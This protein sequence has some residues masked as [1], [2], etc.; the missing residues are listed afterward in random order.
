MKRFFAILLSICSLSA[1]A[2]PQLI[3]ATVKTTA[4]VSGKSMTKAGSKAA[5]KVLTKAFTKY[6]DDALRVARHG[7]VEAIKAGAKHGDDFWRLTRGAAPHAIRSFSLHA[8]TLMPIAKRVGPEFVKLE[9]KVPG[10]G[11]KI[12]STFGD[13]AA[14]SLARTASADDIAKLLG[15][16][17]KADSPATRKL[18]LETYNKGGSKFLNKLNWKVIMATG[19]SA[20]T[21]TAAYK[22]SDGVQ[23]GLKIAAEKDPKGFNN[24]FG[25]S[26]SWISWGLFVVC[27]VFL[28]GPMV[29]L[30]K[31]AYGWWGKRKSSASELAVTEEQK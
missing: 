2:S 26:T 30:G 6:G 22:V 9:G 18:L 28:L 25:H 15:Y 4:K 19:L 11:A 1:M 14:R 16:A 31:L 24:A 13:D 27:I 7:G 3:K 20:A 29:W 17:G 23:D 12:V 21:I 10:L 8:D 5:Q